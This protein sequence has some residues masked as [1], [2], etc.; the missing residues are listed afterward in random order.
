MNILTAIS[1]LTLAA[2]LAP[3]AAA[4]DFPNWTINEICPSEASFAACAEFESRARRL[5][6]APWQT[7]PPEVRATCLRKL[8]REQEKSYRLLQECMEDESFQAQGAR[9]QTRLVE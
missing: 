4:Q 1:A 5:V 3:A 9:R 2:L 8:Q 6:S 7:F